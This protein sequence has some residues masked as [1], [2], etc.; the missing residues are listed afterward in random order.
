MDNRPFALFCDIYLGRKA[1]SENAGVMQF[2]LEAR[3]GFNGDFMALG[4]TC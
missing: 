4:E 1:F 2:E 3:Y